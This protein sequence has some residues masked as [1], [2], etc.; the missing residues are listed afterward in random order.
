VSFQRLLGLLGLGA[1]AA[2]VADT[3]TVRTITRALDRLEPARARF[4]ASFAYL[5]GRVAY[6]D[7]EISDEET[8][9]M[10]R[11]VTEQMGLPAEQAIVAVQI[12]K[13]QARLFGG[14]EDFLV[15]REFAKIATRDEKRALLR[16]LFTV[17]AADQAISS[18]EDDE[19]KRIASELHLER[20]DFL[21]IRSAFREFLTVLKEG[22]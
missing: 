2:P 17:C 5:L 8:A 7:L 6:A 4:V 12:A 21:E 10:E 9:A 16:C 14:T 19:I 1:S 13:S 11:I 18:V 20:Q 15:A 3:E 22:P